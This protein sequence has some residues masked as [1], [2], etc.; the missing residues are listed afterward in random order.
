MRRALLAVLA[1]AILAGCS[2]G[3]ISGSLYGVTV[4]GEAK[5]GADVQVVLVRRDEATGNQLRDLEAARR[6]E[7]APAQAAFD[8]AQ[9]APTAAASSYQ[10]MSLAAASD[11]A[12]SRRSQ[13]AAF[14]AARKVAEIR[15]RYRGHA[16]AILTR[17]NVATVRTD[18]NGGFDFTDISSGTY[19]IVAEWAVSRMEYN[20]VLQHSY[21]VTDRVEWLVPI[22]VTGG[23]NR[24]QLSSSNAGW[25]FGYSQD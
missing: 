7:L 24:V 13:D 23:A 20:R 9:A 4:G 22:D 1:L 25:P 6:A 3:Q 14:D 10:D 5:R 19:W 15:Q 2:R 11:R 8:Q 12:S 18:A 16:L 17:G 21:P